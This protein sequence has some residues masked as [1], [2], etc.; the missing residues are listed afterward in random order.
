MR[1]NDNK[2]RTELEAERKNRGM[3]Q[4]DLAIKSGIAQNRISEYLS[5]KKTMKIITVRKIAEALG[6]DLIL[7][8]EKSTED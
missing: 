4:K 7:T 1:F 8:L 6:F 3:S 5:G 2:I